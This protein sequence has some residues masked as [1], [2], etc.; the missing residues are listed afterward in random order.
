MPTGCSGVSEGGGAATMLATGIARN[1][2]KIASGS[3]SSNATAE[4]PSGRIPLTS[5]VRPAA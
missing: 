4:S 5:L 2:A 1:F 3:V